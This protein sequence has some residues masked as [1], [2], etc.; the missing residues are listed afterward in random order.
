MRRATE[1]E[2]ARLHEDF[3]ELCR[4]ESPYGHERA[5]GQKVKAELAALGLEVHEDGAAQVTGGD[6]GNLFARVPG[7]SARSILLCAHLDTVPLE[8]PVEP[9]AVDE[10]WENAHDAILG[11]DNKAAVAVIL[12]V[13]RR[14]AAGPPP[15]G[16]ELL[17]T[18]AEENALVGAKA[19]DVSRLSSDY[20]YVFDHASPIGEIV[21]A[22]PTYYRLSATF[23]GTAAHA[24]IRPEDGRS[25]IVAA[26][27][28]IAGMSLGRLDEQTT[29]NIGTIR[30]GSGAT[31][32]VPDRCEVLGEARSLDSERVEAVVAEMVDR[33]HDGANL[34]EC[35]C[36]LD[37]SVERLFEGYRARR[38]A[39]HIAVAERALSAC[40]YEPRLISTGGGSDANALEAAGFECGNLAN[41][42]L[43]NHQ[44]DERV[45]F[46]DL[47]GMLDVAMA[48][49]EEAAAPATTPEAA[50]DPVPGDRGDP[51]SGHP[52]DPASGEAREPQGA[53]LSDR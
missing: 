33:L 17:F 36:D 37:I 7:P 35:Q 18:V 44:P 23:R 47:E 8:G 15:I 22:S 27:H 48:L 45:S 10:G 20:G 9:V 4:I 52:Q 34:P 11:A 6:C 21:L 42:T 2:R 38:G 24:G 29:A 3:V 25:A 39:A 13:V 12:G 19:F 50:Q 26:A 43:R 16:L 30:G 14:F 31:N 41:G 46:A 53:A 51:P 28:A 5:C 40:G 32:V 49:V 1:A